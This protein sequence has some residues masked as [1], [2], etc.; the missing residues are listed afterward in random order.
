[1]DFVSGTR[2][3]RPNDEAG[4]RYLIERH[5]VSRR[6][7]GDSSGYNAR[8]DYDAQLL[9]VEY[10]RTENSNSRQEREARFV[11]TPRQPEEQIEAA[12]PILEDDERIKKVMIIDSSHSGEKM[13]PIIY[14]S[15]VIKES[16]SLREAVLSSNSVQMKALRAPD[17]TPEEL[18]PLW[19]HTLQV[20]G[21]RLAD[22]GVYSCHAGPNGAMASIP[23]TIEGECPDN[24]L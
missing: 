1:M 23:I 12:T 4:S 16:Q 17:G 22:Q 10:A 13:L 7:G 18:M 14:S 21:A 15:A 3:L 2:A 19:A 5:P 11:A 8:R 9:N 20:V 6:K 24:F